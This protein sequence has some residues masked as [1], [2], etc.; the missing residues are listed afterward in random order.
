MLVWG[1]W[2]LRFRSILVATDYSSASATAVK[3][4]ARLAKEFH[5]HLMCFMRLSPTSCEQ[6]SEEAAVPELQLRI[7][8]LSARTSTICRAHR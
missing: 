4:A 2:V 8:S 7:C 1:Q 5:A 6:T 3:L